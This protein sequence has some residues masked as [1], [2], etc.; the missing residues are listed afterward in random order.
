MG[1]IPTLSTN[2]D[3]RLPYYAKVGWVRSWFMSGSDIPALGEATSVGQVG[4]EGREW[5]Q[6]QLSDFPL[7]LHVCQ[8]PLVTGYPSLKSF[9][10]WD[11]QFSVRLR[12]TGSKVLALLDIWPQA[13]FAYCKSKLFLPD[14][15]ELCNA[16]FSPQ[17]MERG[18]LQF[19]TLFL[20]AFSVF[21]TSS[22]PYW[23]GTA[24]F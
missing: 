5:Q 4:E 12:F 10:G 2:F 8:N 20:P 1:S 24:V 23:V 6:L 21:L 11:L 15:P 19:E 16:F 9:L 7:L 22:L 17:H 18:G 14:E 13:I 3:V